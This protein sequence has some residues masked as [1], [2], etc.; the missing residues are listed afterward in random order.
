MDSAVHLLEYI[1]LIRPQ[2]QPPIGNKLMF[3]GDL[4]VMIVGGPNE[5]E[6]YHIEF[7]EELFYMLQGSMTLKIVFNYEFIDI[8]IREGEFFLLPALIPHSPQREAN[9]IGLVFERTRHENEPD[10]LRW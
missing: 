3:S 6:D 9:T 7:G 8:V 4:K 1:D 2:L 10:T 5:R